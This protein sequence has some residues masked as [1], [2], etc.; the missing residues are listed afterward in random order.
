VVEAAEDV[1]EQAGWD[2]LLFNLNGHESTRRKVLRTAA[3]PKRVDA[4]MLV[5]T[6][7][8]TDDFE[9][10]AGLQL[11][12]VTIS[13]GAAVPGWPSFRIDDVQAARAATQHLIDLGHVRIAHLTG[14]PDDELT[15][16]TPGDRRAGYLEAMAGVG[17]DPD[18]ALCQESHFT[19]A[20]GEFATRKLLAAA[21][22]PPTAIFAACDEMAIGAL[23]AL[24]FAGLRVPEDVS[25]IGID[26]HDVSVAV[27][28]TTVAQPAAEQGRL[29][30]LALLDALHGRPPADSVTLRTQ[31]VVR[32]S[33][34]P[35]RPTAPSSRTRQLR[36]PRPR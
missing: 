23:R 4:L 15:Y 35:P 34:A 21:D 17:V 18:P 31:L 2:L 25:V 11:P 16:T 26:D 27:G 1:F 7:L 20:G 14:D 12:G 32:E 5:A 3:L 36:A 8:L 13:S 28:L 9:V 22:T 19:V 6:P 24:R 29:G 30:A 10:V 33:T